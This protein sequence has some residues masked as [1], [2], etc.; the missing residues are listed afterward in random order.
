MTA[1]D[2][3]TKVQ[4]TRLVCTRGMADP[5]DIG[6]I[7]DFNGLSVPANQIPTGSWA[8]TVILTRK[9]RR[10]IGDATYTLN[11]NPDDTTQR[12]IKEMEGTD[13]IASYDLI[14]P[15]GTIKTRTFDA[16]VMQFGDSAKNDGI[17]MG[18]IT[19]GVLAAPVRS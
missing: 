12:Q 8:D 19:L 9:G 16:M 18:S 2:H 3:T 14:Y 5:F 10:K 4:A 6:E 17:Y 13:E 1:I 7:V 11:L 15:E